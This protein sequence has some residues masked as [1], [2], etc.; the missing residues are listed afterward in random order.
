MA[1]RDQSEEVVEIIEFDEDETASNGSCSGDELDFDPSQDLWVTVTVKKPIKKE[2][3]E[4][5]NWEADTDTT[6]TSDQMTSRGAEAC[7]ELLALPRVVCLPLVT[8]PIVVQTL[9]LLATPLKKLYS[10]V[11]HLARLGMAWI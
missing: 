1:S 8:H 5:W 3:E 11:A 10:V 2:E 6:H 7:Q 9:R 4:E